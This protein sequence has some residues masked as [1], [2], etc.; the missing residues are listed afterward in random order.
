MILE[1][2]SLE[3][4][5]LT[6]LK[7]SS[8]PRESDLEQDAIEWIRTAAYYLWIEG[9]YVNGLHLKHWDQAVQLYNDCR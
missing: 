4:E 9:G 5:D 3:P 6:K 1:E 2:H 8:Q 7:R